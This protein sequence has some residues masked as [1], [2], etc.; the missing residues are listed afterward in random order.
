MKLAKPLI[1]KLSLLLLVSI[2]M[3]P[4]TVLALLVLART[5]AT[6]EDS[7][8]AMLGFQWRLDLEATRWLNFKPPLQYKMPPV[9][10]NPFCSIETDINNVVFNLFDDDV[11]GM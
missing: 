11:S 3:S 5:A 7:M 10:T 6:V 1:T 9:T 8:S 2:K 4:L